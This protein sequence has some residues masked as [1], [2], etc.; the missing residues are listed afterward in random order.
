LLGT[1][2][3][4]TTEK[5]VEQRYGD[6]HRL[7]FK[8]VKVPYTIPHVYNPDFTLTHEAGTT[9]VEVKGYFQDSAEAA[10]YKWVREALAEGE[11]LVFI[12]ENPN[13]T[14]HFLSKRKDG[15]KQSMAEWADRNKFK[16]YTLESFKEVFDDR[17]TTADS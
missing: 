17:E 15:T 7:T 13:K 2:W 4:S 16:W 10:K 11:E 6:S 1:K 12:F 5:E 14:L 8:G 9:Y 3:D